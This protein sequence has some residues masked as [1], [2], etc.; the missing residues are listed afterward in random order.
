MVPPTYRRYIGDHFLG[1]RRV[2]RLRVQMRL[3]HVFG[4]YYAFD[5]LDVEDGVTQL[6][7]GRAPTTRRVDPVDPFWS[8]V[9]VVGFMDW[10]V[11]SKE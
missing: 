6:T 2:P 3:D 8:R 9:Y 7:W 11:C 5:A 10:S 1:G 4:I